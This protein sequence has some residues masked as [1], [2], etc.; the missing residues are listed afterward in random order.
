[1]TQIINRD[2]FT[3]DKFNYFEYSIEGGGILKLK[4]ALR[5]K[6]VIET[7]ILRDRGPDYI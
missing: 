6:N 5:E 2:Y 1:M 7:R 3:L 4:L